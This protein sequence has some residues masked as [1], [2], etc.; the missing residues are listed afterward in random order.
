MLETGVG[1]VGL[2][3]KSGAVEKIEVRKRDLVGVH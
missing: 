1:E 3:V 2:V